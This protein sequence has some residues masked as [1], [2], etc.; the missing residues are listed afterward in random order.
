MRSWIRSATSA[1]AG[2]L[3]LCGHSGGG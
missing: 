1:A 2:V 3:A